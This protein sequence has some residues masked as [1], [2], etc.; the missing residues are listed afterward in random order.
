MNV[1]VIQGSS[2]GP[3]LFPLITADIGLDLDVNHEEFANDF[4]MYHAISTIEDTRHFHG[5]IDKFYAWCCLNGLTLNI[6][7]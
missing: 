1:G 7:K 3:T 5:Q 2:L 6:K 4:K